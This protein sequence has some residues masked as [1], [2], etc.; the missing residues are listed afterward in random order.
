VPRLEVK[1]AVRK[2]ALSRFDKELEVIEQKLASGKQSLDKC[3]EIEE[4]QTSL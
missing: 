1:V 3:K 2:S 4:I